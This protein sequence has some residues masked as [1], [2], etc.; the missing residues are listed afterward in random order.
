MT[1]LTPASG[2]GTPTPT[3]SGCSPTPSFLLQLVSQI[4]ANIPGPPLGGFHLPCTPRHLLPIATVLLPPSHLH[5]HVLHWPPPQDAEGAGQSQLS[6][7]NEQDVE[8]TGTQPGVGGEVGPGFLRPSCPCPAAPAQ[9]EAK[10]SG[11]GQ[12]WALAAR[13]LHTLLGRHAA[14]LPTEG[15]ST[16]TPQHNLGTSIFGR[17]EV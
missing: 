12:G 1:K 11:K 10:G 15:E 5:H 8:A 14:K 17:R 7:S 3:S 2:S 13:F 4:S 9:R 6:P 16:P